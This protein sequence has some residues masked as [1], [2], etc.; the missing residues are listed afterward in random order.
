MSRV[1]LSILAVGLLATALSSASAAETRAAAHWRHCGNQP[2]PGAGWY[3]VKA[4]RIGCAKARGVA[5]HYTA[6]RFAGNESPAPFGFSC[7]EMQV[8]YEL[9]EVACRR[10]VGGMIQKVRFEYGA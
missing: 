1:L 10:S 3:Q 4:L 7:N 9:T 2:S 6:S 5:R 8:G